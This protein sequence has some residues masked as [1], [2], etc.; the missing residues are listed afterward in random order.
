[1]GYTK[2]NWENLPS[3]NTPI[4]AERLNH[5]EDGIEEAWEHGGGGGGG[6]DI[7]T[8]VPFS[9]AIA[10]IP[11]GFMLCDGS[12]ISRTTYAT[13]FSIIGTTYGEGDGSTTFNLPNLQGK[14]LVGVD[15]E[16]T[17]FDTL[18]ETGG[19]KTHTL[20]TSEMPSHNHNRIRVVAGNQFLGI[21][22]GSY[23]NV[24]GLNLNSGKYPYTDETNTN[25]ETS[26]TGGG[27]SHNNLQPYITI[28]YIIK[29]LYSQS[30]DIRSES[31]PVGTELD[32]DGQVSEIPTGWEQIPQKEFIIATTTTDSRTNPLKVEFNSIFSKTGDFTLNDGGI[33]I[34][35]GISKV[36]VSANI[37]LEDPQ[38]NGYTMT[39]IVHSRN[40]TEVN[41]GQTIIAITTGSYVSSTITPTIVEV[42]EGDVLY[43]KGENPSRAKIRINR[44]NT[45]ILIEKYI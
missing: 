37:F 30:G 34:P 18:G 45:W 4:T 42:E 8:I 27:Q 21:A 24:A 25:V 6:I 14:T 10:Q 32:F 5:M 20:L 35:A 36:K 15:S 3:T 19:E 28:N 22:G 44:P 13:L 31:L 26:N 39:S 33:V 12:A 41:Q 9:G 7:G 2:Q 23:A 16:D 29:V 17:D 40:G 11:N 43:I 1:M 38:Y